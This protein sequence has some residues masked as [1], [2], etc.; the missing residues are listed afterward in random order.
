MNICV[1]IKQV[2][3]TAEAG[4]DPETGRIN[5]SGLTNIL[6]PLDLNALE[7]AARLKE[8]YGGRV[9]ALSMGP[10]QA[11]TALREAL[12]RGADRG[13]L[14]TDR[15]FAGGDT[16]ATSVTLALAV[17]RLEA[18]A[19]KKF[20]LLI[21]GRQAVDGDTAQVP[22]ELSVSLGIPFVG[23]VRKIKDVETDRAGNFG[24]VTA[25]SL[26]DKGYEILRAPLPAVMTVVKDINV[27]R[28][29]SF[30]DWVR[31]R[32][33]VPDHLSSADLD[34]IGERTG[35]S[36][37]PT[38]VLRISGVDHAKKTEFLNPDKKGDIR[39]LI[40]LFTQA[41]GRGGLQN[42]PA[43]GREPGSGEKDLSVPAAVLPQARVKTERPLVLVLGELA[44]DPATGRTG[45]SAPT[46]ELAAAAA[47][48]ARAGNAR[49]GVCFTA[50]GPGTVNPAEDA[51]EGEMLLPRK[52]TGYFLFFLHGP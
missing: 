40:S 25:E 32:E 6:N 12:A 10:A 31:A 24:F 28:L 5:R 38:R 11:E 22:P 30:P 37:S 33:A 1:C 14:C 21:C 48:L 26:I 9:T 7:E 23:C 47:G 16:W 4:M 18:E 43:S 15:R 46:L 13:V 39:K 8:K 17:R 2:P 45:I 51:P 49:L 27:P 52:W 41:L 3:D 44:T 42:Q 34:P 20:D 36:G 29:P 35:A 19:G 50:A